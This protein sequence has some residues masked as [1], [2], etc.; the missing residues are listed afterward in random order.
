MEQMI[1]L[2]NVQIL[3]E[4]KKIFDVQYLRKVVNWILIVENDFIV[5]TDIV[6]LKNIL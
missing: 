4:T 3:N 6:K 1:Q 2:I 5:M